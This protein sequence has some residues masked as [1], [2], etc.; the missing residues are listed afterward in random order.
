MSTIVAYLSVN[1][2]DQDDRSFCKPLSMTWG[3]ANVQ[4][5]YRLGI[6]RPGICLEYEQLSDDGLDYQEN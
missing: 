2:D 5:W 4:L 6:F 3:A 1:N